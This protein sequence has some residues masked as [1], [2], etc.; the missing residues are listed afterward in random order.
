M[1]MDN[2]LQAFDLSLLACW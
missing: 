1:R 2:N